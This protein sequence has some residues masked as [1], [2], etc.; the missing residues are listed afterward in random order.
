MLF[1]VKLVEHLN[2]MNSGWR[3]NTVIMI[4]NAQ[5]HRGIEVMEQLK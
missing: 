5:Y 4:D 1:I 3:K 2:G